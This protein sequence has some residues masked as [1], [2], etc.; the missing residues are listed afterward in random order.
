MRNN[1]SGAQ[2][3]RNALRQQYQQQVNA[4]VQQ[5]AAQRAAGQQD[6]GN[7]YQQL[8][9]TVQDNL[10]GFAGAIDTYNKNLKAELEA[11][12]KAEQAAQKAWAAQA[13]KDIKAARKS[14]TSTK[15]TGS[16]KAAEDASS[17]ESSAAENTDSLFGTPGKNGKG[18]AASGSNAKKDE[19]K[20]DE[21]S[22]TL[23]KL[24][25]FGGA[26]D[27]WFKSES[28]A[29]QQL[30]E[31][32]KKDTAA[33]NESV[34]QSV[35]RYKADKSDEARQAAAQSNKT[36]ASKKKLTSSDKEVIF[37]R[38]NNWIQQGNNRD[39]VD[40][41]N[42]IDE[43][44][45]EQQSEVQGAGWN[46]NALEQKLSQY[47]KNDIDLANEYRAMY[48]R[49]PGYRVSERTGNTA[50][51]VGKTILSAPM[52]A[53]DYAGQTF[54]NAVASV[55]NEEYRNAVKQQNSSLL[56]MQTMEDQGLA[57]A[58]NE[59]GQV[60]GET[61]QYKALREQF[62]S[63]KAVVDNLS[64][65]INQPVSKES[66][67]YQMYQSGQENLMRSDMGLSDAQKFVKG[68]ATSAA[69]N[70]AIAALNPG[71]VLPVLSAQGAADSFAQSTANE[72]S[73]FT[74]LVKGAAKGMAGY[75][76]NSVGVEQM[77]DTM[78]M[79]GARNT[80][81]SKVVQ[82]MKNDSVL[83]GFA[84]SNPALYAVL[85]GATDNGLQS[86]AETWAD[87][88]IDLATNTAEPKSMEQLL[89]ESLQSMASGATGGAMTAVAGL[90]VNAGRQ[91][92][93]NKVA[94]NAET[95]QQNVQ[96]ETAEKAADN[97]APAEQNHTEQNAAVQDIINNLTTGENGGNGNTNRTAKAF[98]L[99]V[100]PETAQKNAENRAALAAAL[101]V[102]E[103]A[104]PTN[105]KEMRQFIQGLK[106][107]DFGK[108]NN[109]VGEI[110]GMMEQKQQENAEIRDK[111]W[112]GEN[113]S[114]EISE[115]AG[116]PSNN[117]EADRA[118][119]TMRKS[120]ISD[121]AESL[122]RSSNQAGEPA[123]TRAFDQ[124]YRAGL[125]GN[126]Q[127]KNTAAYA[128]AGEQAREI[129]DKAYQQGRADRIA[130]NHA[131]AAEFVPSEVLNAKHNKDLLFVDKPKDKGAQ[132][133]GK[134][135]EKIARAQ[136][137]RNVFWVED[138]P[139]NGKK[140]G[141]GNIYLNANL[142]SGEAV[143]TYFGHEITHIAESSKF[144]KDLSK[145]IQDSETGKEWVRQRGFDSF[146][147]YAEAK[148]RIYADKADQTGN[149]SY[150]LASMDE[151]MQE[152]IAD[153]C[154][155]NLLGDSAISER[156]IRELCGENRSFA[157]KVKDFLAD[158]VERFLGTSEED[159]LRHALDL[160]EKA[161]G[162]SNIASSDKN[163]VGANGEN[164][165]FSYSGNLIDD[166]GI[167]RRE[168]R[169]LQSELM[170]RYNTYNQMHDGVDRI[171][172]V[173]K[174]YY[175]STENGVVTVYKV[176]EHND[177][178]LERYSN[179]LW[180][181]RK[182]QTDRHEFD[183]N[184]GRFGNGEGEHLRND[185][186]FDSIKAEGRNAELDE[187]QRKRPANGA[188]SDGNGS[189]IFGIK[190]Q[191][192]DDRFGRNGWGL[193]TEEKNEYFDTNTKYSIREEEPP[194]K[195]GVAY[196]VFLLKDG[197]LYP[198]MVANPGGAGTDV[199]VWLNADAAPRAEDSKTGRMQVQAG[200]KGT[201]TGKTT[202]AYRPG[203][204]LGDIPNAAQFAKK[205][206]ETGVKDLFPSNF[207]WAECEY[208]MD[209]DYQD[210]AMSYGYNKNGKF[211]H[212]LAGLPKIPKDGFYRYRTNPRP[213]TVPWVITGA[214]KVNRIL[215]DAET[216]QI[217]LKNGVTPMKR[218][219]GP[220]TA[221]RIKS[222]GLA[223]LDYSV[224]KNATDGSRNSLSTDSK[225]ET[226]VSDKN[227]NAVAELVRFSLA[228][229]VEE[230]KNLVAVHNSSVKGL[231]ESLK[232]GGLPS[233]S[234]AIVK[235][236]D[237]HTEYGDVSLVFDKNTI[238][239]AVSKANKVYGS[240]AWTPTKPR[241]DY[242]VNRDKARSFENEIAELSGKIAHG[243]FES[244]G[245]LGAHGINEITELRVSEIAE[246]L[247]N[248]DAV[249]AAYLADQGKTLEPVMADKEYDRYGNDALHRFIENLGD[250]WVDKVLDG[251]NAENQHFKQEYLDAAIEAITEP[252]KLMGIKQKRAAYL[253]EHPLRVEDFILHAM[254]L[255]AAGVSGQTGID[256]AATSD[257]LREAVDD[258]MVAQWAKEKL[259]GLLG[260]AGIY[261]GRDPFTASGNR[262]S[263]AQLHNAYTLENIVRAMNTQQAARGENA[264]PSAQGMQAVASPEYKSI[265][266]IKADEGRL[267]RVEEAEMKARLEEVSDRI[268][269][270]ILLVREDVPNK[271]GD[272]WQANTIIGEML[273][274]NAQKKTISS[275]KSAFAKDGYAI[276]Q[277]TARQILLMY[278][279]AA[280]LPTEYFEAKPQRAVGFGEVRAAIVPDNAHSGFVDALKNAGVQ[281]VVLYKAGDEAD[282]LNKLNDLQGVRFSL[283]EPD[284]ISKK[285]RELAR[286]NQKLTEQ[287]ERLKTTIGILK[288]EFKR[289]A[290]HKI[291]DQSMNRL[292]S[293]LKGQNKSTIEREVLKQKLTKLFDYVQNA[294]TNELNF[295]DVM[296]VTADIAKDI[297]SN[298]RDTGESL[299]E[300]DTRYQELYKNL[301]TIEVTAEEKAR[302][303]AAYGK[304][305]F[306]KINGIKIKVVDKARSL[307]DVLHNDLAASY[308]EF[309]SGDIASAE[310]A[311]DRMAQVRSA[312]NDPVLNNDSGMSFDEMAYS[313]AQQIWDE[314]LDMPDTRAKTYA[315]K[316]ADKFKAAKEEFRAQ[317]ESQRA[318]AKA[319]YEQ[320]L[321]TVQRENAAAIEQV[322][323]ET[324]G[325]RK[326]LAKANQELADLN[327]RAA[328]QEKTIGKQAEKI[329]KQTETIAENKQKMRDLRSESKEAQKAAR[330][331]V[332]TAYDFGVAD[333]RAVSDAKI[334][335]KQ[336]QIDKL[337]A[338]IK[339]R[340]KKMRDL[341]SEKNQKILETRAKY[342][343][344]MD[345]QRENRAKTELRNR[346]KKNG[347]ALASALAKPTKSKYVPKE[348]VRTAA[349]L[350][351]IIESTARTGK[352]R[353]TQY[354]QKLADLRTL[355]TQM[356]NSKDFDI[357]S[358]YQA[359]V[360]DMIQ[361]LNQ[362]AL[363]RN[364]N[365]RTADTV[366]EVQ[367]KVLSAGQ[368]ADR[369]L[370]D[371]T[372][373]ELAMLNNVISAIKNTISKAGQAHTKAYT[374]S[375]SETRTKA[376][377]EVKA[378]HRLNPKNKAAQAITNQFLNYM[379]PLRLFRYIGG[380]SGNGAV[381][382][383]YN[384]LNDAAVETSAI[385]LKGNSFFSDIAS[386]SKNL[387]KFSGSGA[388]RIKLQTRNETL[389][390]VE[391]EVTPAI[392]A[393]MLDVWAHNPE[394]VERSGFVIP[395]LALYHKGM[396]KQAY[397]NGTVIKP[398]AEQWLQ[399]SADS[400]MYSDYAKQ[401][402]KALSEQNAYIAPKMRETQL[403]I[404]GFTNI[405]EGDHR[406]LYRDK[407]Y[408][409]GTTEIVGG[410]KTLVHDGFTKNRV[411]G[412]RQP[413]YAMDITEF[414]KKTVHDTSVF[415]GMSAALLDFSR[416]YDGPVF[417]G[418]VDMDG[419]QI[420]NKTLA[421]MIEQQYTP[422]ATNYIKNLLD[423]IREQPRA[424]Q[425]AALGKL[426]GNVASA[427]LSMN[428]I[429]T[430]IKQSPSFYAASSVIGLK[431]LLKTNA[432]LTKQY[433]I[434]PE[435]IMQY[436]PLLALRNEQ[437]GSQ[438]LAALKRGT[439][440]IAGFTAKLPGTKLI[441]W[442]DM[443]TVKA[444]WAAS[445]DY[446]HSRNASLDTDS[447]EF[448]QEVAKVFNRCVQETQPNYSTLQR[449]EM[450]RSGNAFY[451]ILG[452]F[453]TQPIQN[454]NIL[455]DAYLNMK[456]NKGSK[457]ASKEF[458]QALAGQTL[459]LVAFVAL[460]NL[461]RLI[462]HQFKY[463]T[464]PDKEEVTA[465][466][467]AKAFGSDAL[468]SV[469]GMIPG[470]TEALE[471]V[472]GYDYSNVTTSFIND[473]VDSSK[474]VYDNFPKIFDEE[475][476]DSEREAAKNKVLK[477][478]A[479]IIDLTGLPA[480]TSVRLSDAVNGWYKDITAGELNS[481]QKPT[482]SVQ[483]A[484]LYKAYL[485]GDEKQRTLAYDSLI[486]MGVRENEISSA[487]MTKLGNED[488]MKQAAQQY[489]DNFL[490]S[491]D[492]I[493]AVISKYTDLGFREYLVRN[494]VS[495]M[496][497]SIVSKETEESKYEILDNTMDYL[498]SNDIYNWL[499]EEDRAAVQ[500][501]VSGDA[502]KMAKQ[503]AG[504][505]QK[506]SEGEKYLAKVSGGDSDAYMKLRAAYI[507][508]N[509]KATEY[510]KSDKDS[511]NFYNAVT[512][513]GYSK[514]LK[515][516]LLQAKNGNSKLVDASADQILAYYGASAQADTDGNSRVSQDEF[517]D[518][519]QKSGMSQ[520]AA[521]YVW[522]IRWPKG[523]N[524]YL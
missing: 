102:D 166:V 369:S 146:E 148:Y 299:R 75:A 456:A 228:D 235:A 61:Q 165:R 418:Q 168:Y 199:G 255:D 439:G 62:E 347:M 358:E 14:T 480:S 225:A 372:T 348:L 451:R 489:A 1:I 309:F 252:I 84:K 268:A 156:A 242:K 476:S 257:K 28:K 315:D 211:Q 96:T 472:Q 20:K 120:G 191:I 448:K 408:V 171:S 414:A 401:W 467:V 378:G 409:K 21:K 497:D 389:N 469:L 219:G 487:M 203:W 420:S 329:D 301:G 43:I 56:K 499:G 132:R 417:T 308:P 45:N 314:Y 346:I 80:I 322:R 205:N 400:T 121:E 89:Q 15:S 238:D 344:M 118:V 298:S 479:K 396:T 104:L 523:R 289:S 446:V 9:P 78:G 236:K 79:G 443:R 379:T 12:Q 159:E 259:D 217:C 154:G 482:E 331:N 280:K 490:E 495:S 67:G 137:N 212:S 370:N 270:V 53:V 380:Y 253:K 341:R 27:K 505:E 88:A 95:A 514:S 459:S 452:Q 54:D 119:E 58:Y 518:Y 35:A 267:G 190:Q 155:E 87:Y 232:L 416:I 24:I 311:F 73:A 433:A 131:D 481:Q 502:A 279:K 143:R 60:L 50:L 445:A 173:G 68:A 230:T 142:S 436:T 189:E 511:K 18:S 275:I 450:Q 240:D 64:S 136:G 507:A 266:E 250:G 385:E 103:S 157:T 32:A 374:L 323:G 185:A 206:P 231:M 152:V 170:T 359:D 324:I 226:V 101:G 161:L 388:D 333:Q 444:L 398:S 92:L 175:L 381:Q 512:G 429:G 38:Y 124:A 454:G 74:G 258:K 140:D 297:L 222:M 366:T 144:Y 34:A 16:T 453:K 195:T 351:D 25:A 387:S 115:M 506:Y 36:L 263:F 117:K 39:I 201:N 213:D 394:E 422:A 304:A 65:V 406:T 249:R 354:Q 81:A 466:Q 162:E 411:E 471:I 139:F 133:A 269:D 44:K 83:S 290:G 330:R 484:R 364:P 181:N 48:N 503:Q 125:D 295:D 319:E 343:G 193:S 128:M 220:L 204:H 434:T 163:S 11:Q 421:G 41:L 393:N 7:T 248:D 30:H 109:Y 177:E 464:D 447:T 111:S 113:L 296:D 300:S 335:A 320:S 302:I 373:S 510:G 473:F 349:D 200:G 100:S 188:G 127:N 404:Q 306:G 221:E 134:L 504:Y 307:D 239:P 276:S 312:L 441:S 208:A 164:A 470:G 233:P 432:Q 286:Q 500:Q 82:Y 271:V 519:V 501:S 57:Y 395:D 126:A 69:E 202:L 353:G 402:S 244:Y 224:E 71:L 262:R 172:T 405:G 105:N 424:D 77:V 112:N 52:Q 176:V 37:N 214:M 31:T 264:M 474:R 130:Q 342:R 76:I 415:A 153:W 513:S 284:T 26:V 390:D 122:Y 492:E 40:A 187:K 182:R 425:S 19:S 33:L 114:G 361:E 493:E 413:L 192:L 261:N 437:G 321:K 256:R 428:V 287:N 427:S 251:F 285:N 3:Y 107:D 265:S 517:K 5:I 496:A 524:P 475:L 51:G 246:K 461:G 49:I 167:S 455:L 367:S 521:A 303:E 355:Y 4:A 273:V 362:K 198:P 508:A 460:G 426:L 274:E 483:K 158:M 291:A 183:G 419:D 465:E 70:I 99:N 468:S 423:D 2:A 407:I 215:T 254:N 509:R 108:S 375:L 6:M 494:K 485:S 90:G 293:R 160:F 350:C 365:A 210:E 59:K 477:G 327:K 209:H 430:P 326:R 196:K 442:V 272:S 260:E 72:E 410:G 294:E 310:D 47:S 340:Q 281:E 223:E 449:S 277:E 399:W 384:S 498:E 106:P 334:A 241:V 515:S 10:G 345:K 55:T 386:D 356:K 22:G 278:R 110:D 282:R 229:P 382:Q 440:K 29:E 97:R 403:D 94:S 332:N 8:K 363:S 23:Q 392:M 174:D 91:A 184:D 147:E 218:M 397:S 179:D 227:G 178:N 516:A 377:D 237:G 376:A 412:A 42:A 17:E 391:V 491:D 360:D 325:L 207:V 216:D 86:F 180:S 145:F 149:E 337:K 371:L 316:Q 313:L 186:P 305:Q 85:M 46:K 129:I 488:D 194:H 317:L 383:M 116:T 438:E 352:S 435:E 338:D 141:N 318:E 245:Q 197:K 123:F 292:V 283:N 336:K 150:R 243:T 520:S 458:G 462:M 169:M 98:Y 63:A 522:S 138:A 431:P 247:A 135:V 457:A 66:E 93:Y 151:A 288:G 478:A 339:D 368:F 13:V 234:I 357:S 328:A 486:G 463:W